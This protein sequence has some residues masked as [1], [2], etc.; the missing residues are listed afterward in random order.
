MPTCRAYG[1]GCAG[2]CSIFGEVESLG[3]CSFFGEVDSL[4]FCSIFGEVDSLGFC[5]L[6]GE[7]DSLGLVAVSFTFTTFSY[8]FVLIF[9]HY[10]SFFLIISLLLRSVCM[11]LTFSPGIQ[12]GIKNVSENKNVSGLEMYKIK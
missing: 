2:C 6:F 3:F 11:I 8:S 10:R 1:C 7:V 12:S 5:S 9:S 4:G